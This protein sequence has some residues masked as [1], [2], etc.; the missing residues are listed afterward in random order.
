MEIVNQSRETTLIELLSI[1]GVSEVRGQ[2]ADADL[3]QAYPSATNMMNAENGLNNILEEIDEYYSAYDYDEEVIGT[4]GWIVTLTA[5]ITYYLYDKGYVIGSVGSAMRMA[6]FSMYDIFPSL[7]KRICVAYLLIV[8]LDKKTNDLSSAISIRH[9]KAQRDY[10]AE[11]AVYNMMDTELGL[12]KLDIPGLP[13]EDNLQC[14][15]RVHEGQRPSYKLSAILY[16]WHVLYCTASFYCVD[17]MV[18]FQEDQANKKTESKSLTKAPSQHPLGVFN[19]PDVP[20]K[21]RRLWFTWNHQFDISRMLETLQ[22][23]GIGQCIVRMF[24]EIHPRLPDLLVAKTKDIISGYKIFTY[25]CATA[26]E[27]LSKIE[28]DEKDKKTGEKVTKN[29]MDRI[30]KNAEEVILKKA[31]T[32]EPWIVSFIL[33]DEIHFFGANNISPNR[34]CVYDVETNE[35]DVYWADLPITSWIKQKYLKR[36]LGA[37]FPDPKKNLRR[38]CTSPYGKCQELWTTDAQMAKTLQMGLYVTREEYR[39]HQEKKEFEEKDTKD[40]RLIPRLVMRENLKRPV[41]YAT[42]EEKENDFVLIKEVIP[43]EINTY[44]APE[45][46]I[47]KECK[48]VLL[49]NTLP[50]NQYSR[51]HI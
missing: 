40:G 33:D 2:T 43:M 21:Y 14:S 23:E 17:A 39:N 8:L 34:L 35:M 24:E 22:K 15:L 4:D 41:A 11:Y 3:T 48:H 31:R 28:F 42:D 46:V 20:E 30:G 9:I 29:Y 45:D 36:W 37:R 6:G 10:P 51:H 50:T 5:C 13:Y 38:V 47:A 18:L 19:H 1:N 32:K 7:P 26:E 16:K 27:L 12:H 44:Y 25:T 49:E